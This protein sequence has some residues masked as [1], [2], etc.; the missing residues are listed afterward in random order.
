MFIT[1]LKKLYAALVLSKHIIDINVALKIFQQISKFS[2]WHWSIEFTIFK[3][4]FQL[5]YL[6][7]CQFPL[8]FLKFYRVIDFFINNLYSLWRVPYLFHFFVRWGLIKFQYWLFRPLFD[9][10]HLVH[11]IL[12]FELSLYLISSFNVNPLHFPIPVAVT[13]IQTRSKTR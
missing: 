13:T 6:S 1:K 2:F 3:L 9:Y 11:V 5:Y 10:I 8:A 4:F 12:C 7:T